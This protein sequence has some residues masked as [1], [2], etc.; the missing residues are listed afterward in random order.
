M[1]LQDALVLS[2]PQR[3]AHRLERLAGIQLA[4][5]EHQEALISIINGRY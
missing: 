3:R 5:R 2:Q 1:N 4:L